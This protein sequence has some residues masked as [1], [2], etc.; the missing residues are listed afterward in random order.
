M[1]LM[2]KLRAMP[3]SEIGAWSEELMQLWK[4]HAHYS[5]G[6]KTNRRSLQRPIEKS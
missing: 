2:A 6:Y 1:T 5:G 3:A 4:S